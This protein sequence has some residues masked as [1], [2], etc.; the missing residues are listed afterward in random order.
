MRRLVVN[1]MHSIQKIQH[2]T[3]KLEIFFRFCIDLCH[4][5]GSLIRNRLNEP[6]VHQRQRPRRNRKSQAMRDMVKENIVTPK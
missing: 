2:S 3:R 4:I 1:I 6:W 5:L